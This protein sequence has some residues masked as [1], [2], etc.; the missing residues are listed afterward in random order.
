MQAFRL[1]RLP[2][3]PASSRGL[4]GSAPPRRLYGDRGMDE[5]EAKTT[6]SCRCCVHAF[7][8]PPVPPRHFQDECKSWSARRHRL[9]CE[10]ESIELQPHGS[11]RLMGRGDPKQFMVLFEQPKPQCRLDTQSNLD[12][13]PDIGEDP[14][15]CDVTAAIL[16]EL[17]AGF[18]STSVC[19]DTLTGCIDHM[20]EHLDLQKTR[21]D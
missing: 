13:P 6:R 17:R 21:I 11:L 5:P 16:A 15:D 14:D 12:D 3:F 2:V 18:Q 7:C 4:T 9:A 20:G 19:F 1:R 8:I 10:V